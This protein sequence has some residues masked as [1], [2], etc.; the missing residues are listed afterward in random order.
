MVNLYLQNVRDAFELVKNMNLKFFFW[1]VF[2]AVVI[3]GSDFSWKMPREYT[4]DLY[5]LINHLESLASLEN[6]KIKNL[7][8][9]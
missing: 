6:M 4:R 9:Q 3:H 8:Q 7:V 1:Q 2:L 5:I